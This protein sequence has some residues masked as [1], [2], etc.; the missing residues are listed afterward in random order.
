MSVRTSVRPWGRA[1]LAGALALTALSFTAT[2]SALQR[3]TSTGPAVKTWSPHSGKKGVKVSFKGTG[4]SSVT[5]VTWVIY[6]G[7]KDYSA[8][9]TKS[10]TSLVATA[11]AAYPTK[12]GPGLIEFKSKTGTTVVDCWGAC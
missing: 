3:D 5:A 1:T 4:L 2:A 7:P 8:K 6:P 11:P 10:A 9:F 12:P